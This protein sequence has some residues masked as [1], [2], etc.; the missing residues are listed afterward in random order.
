MP[1]PRPASSSSDATPPFPLRVAAVDVGSNAIRYAAAEFTAPG[2]YRMIDQ[3]RVPLR[4]GSDA[5]AAGE[6]SD[7]T[8]D[9]VVRTLAGF[10]TRMDALGVRARRAVATSATRDSRNGAELAARVR[11]EAG[12][13][14]EIIGGAEEARLAWAAVA[15]AV[16]MGSAA[17]VTVD[18]GGG[19]VE[20]SLVD[21][22]GI[23]WSES[24]PLGAVRLLQ[25]AGADPERLRPLIRDAL[26]TLRIPASADGAPPRGLIATGGNADALAKLVGPKPGRG[27]TVHLPLATLRRLIATLAALTPEERIAQLGLRRDRADVV[28]PGALVYESVAEIVGV[29][30][31]LVPGVSLRDGILVD[32]ANTLIEG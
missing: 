12:V 2:A 18:V 26:A 27:R 30:E 13:E 17:W 8:M 28:L 3:E 14:L 16:A 10:R 7:A 4:L 25:A 23:R 31:I 32:L 21:A 5:F 29:D 24:R 6:L 20:V 19:S 11:R 15:S 1:K 22:G 9:A